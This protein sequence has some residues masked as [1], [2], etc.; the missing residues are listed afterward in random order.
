MGRGKPKT[1]TAK[2]TLHVLV[3]RT[4]DARKGLATI[5]VRRNNYLEER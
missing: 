2:M 1:S 4:F 5:K 3:L